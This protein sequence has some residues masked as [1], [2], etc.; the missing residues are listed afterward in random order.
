MK[1][2]MILIVALLLV[3][4]A[5]CSSMGAQENNMETDIETEAS[6]DT[7]GNSLNLLEK[8]IR[9]TCGNQSAIFQLYDT[10]AAQNLYEQLPLELELNNFRNA[11]WMF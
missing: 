7:E 1:K 2:W 11:Q 4:A 3:V 6:A 8:A 10:E 9:V 5:A